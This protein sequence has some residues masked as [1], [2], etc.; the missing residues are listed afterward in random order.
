MTT[1]K[2][3]GADPSAALAGSG[4][5]D[6]SVQLRIIDLHGNLPQPSPR[7]P[8]LVL[9]RS[10][11]TL[12]TYFVPSELAVLHW[13]PH[14]VEAAVPAAPNNVPNGVAMNFRRSI[15]F[16]VV[17]SQASKFHLIHAAGPNRL[18]F[19]DA[20]LSEIRIYIVVILETDR[21]SLLWL[22][23]RDYK[24]L[25]CSRLSQNLG[26]KVLRV[27]L[28][29]VKVFSWNNARLEANLVKLRGTDVPSGRSVVV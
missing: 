5:L 17:N 16:Q 9:H 2:P 22:A 20:A 6:V 28:T 27:I 4:P 13:A 29:Q 11:N 24:H 19:L 14:V 7:V 21:G 26:A 1:V 15:G 12:T 25:T 18:L 8:I 23:L 3:G 10:S